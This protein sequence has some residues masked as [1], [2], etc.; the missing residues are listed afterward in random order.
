MSGDEV[1]HAEYPVLDEAQARFHAVAGAFEG[2]AHPLG[3]ARTAAL[4]GAGELS[5]ELEGGV[6]AFWLSWTEVVRTCADSSRLIAGNIGA[7]A[8]DLSAADAGA[9]STIDLSPAPGGSDERE[10]ASPGLRPR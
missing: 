5:G 1:L 3:A 2:A 6:A 8:V 4:A 9:A 7:T 10:R